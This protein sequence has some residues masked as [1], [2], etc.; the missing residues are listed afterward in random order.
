MSNYRMFSVLAVGALLLFGVASASASLV[1]GYSVGQVQDLLSVE[2]SVHELGTGFPDDQL[3]T[4]ALIGITDTTACPQLDLAAVA[5]VVVSITNNTTTSWTEVYYVADPVTSM[6][7]IDGFIGNP[8][9]GDAQ[10]AFRNCQ[11]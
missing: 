9:L 6:T 7:N 11:S 8:A 1:D 4:S 3:I 2:G 5:N 10:Q